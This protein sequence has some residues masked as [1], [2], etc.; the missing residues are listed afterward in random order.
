[1]TKKLNDEERVKKAYA[2]RGQRGQ[3]MYNF[4]IDIENYEYLQRQSN[5]G[6]WLNNLI[7]RE[8]QKG[9]GL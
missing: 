9:E 6:R 7:E 2:P 4:R 3:R 8:R 1:M 5:K